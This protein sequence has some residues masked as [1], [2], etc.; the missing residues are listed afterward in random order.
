SL[1]RCIPCLK[2]ISKEVDTR[3]SAT[4]KIMMPSGQAIVH[5]LACSGKKQTITTE[6]KDGMLDF[7]QQIGQ[8]PDAYLKRKLPVWHT[9]W[10]DVIRIFQT[11]WGRTTG[12]NTNPASLGFSAA[13]IGRSAPANMKKVEFY[14]GTQLLY[15][16]LDA[17]LLDI[18]RLAFKTDDI[19]VY[20]EEL[21]RTGKLPDKETLL[22][23]ARKLYRAYGTAR[24]R[25]HAMHDTGMASEWAQTVPAGTPWVPQEIEDSSLDLKKR[26]GTKK[27]LGSAAQKTRKAKQ[28]PVPKPCLGDFVLAQGINFIRDGINSRKLMIFVARGDIGRLCECLKYILFTFGGS[29][30][31]NY[32]NYVLE[33][34]DSR[35][36]MQPRS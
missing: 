15:L 25:D 28:K 11:H 3:L 14:T 21:E 24:G 36:G 35:T 22:P 30:H 17:K 1:G 6:L 10:K 26:K 12:K 7:F 27:A 8:T 19:F 29:T 32:L 33:G 18:W 2:P 4:A 16:V 13:R 31:T 23:M 9:K 34:Y 20:F 5:P